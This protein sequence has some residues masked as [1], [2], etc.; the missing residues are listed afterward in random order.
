MLS[1]SRDVFAISNY[2]ILQ[3]DNEKYTI[4]ASV[5]GAEEGGVIIF[6]ANSEAVGF[7]WSYRSRDGEGVIIFKA[8]SDAIGSSY[9]LEEQNKMNYLTKH[10]RLT[11]NL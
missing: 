6:T 1:S 9:G 3:I 5:L 8:N 11:I 10:E 7:S 2:K 4:Y